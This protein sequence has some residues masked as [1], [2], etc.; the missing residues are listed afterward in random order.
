MG[1]GG[2]GHFHAKRHDLLDATAH[3]GDGY[4]A[5]ANT[6][7]SISASNPLAD[8]QYVDDE[9]ASVQ[10]GMHWQ[11]NIIEFRAMVTNE[12]GSPSDGDSYISTETGTIPSTTQAVTANDICRWNS[13]TSQW[14][15]QTPEDGWA[16]I[17]DG[18]EPNKAWIFNGTTW[19]DF[20]SM[21]NHATLLNRNW[22]VAAHT[23][24]TDFDLN[25]NKAINLADCTNDN[26]AVPYHRIREPRQAIGYYVSD[27]RGGNSDEDGSIFNPFEDPND[28][29]ALGVSNG[30]GVIILHMDTR[31]ATTYT[32]NVPAGEKV[33]VYGNEPLLTQLCIVKI[34]VGDGA[35]VNHD[36]VFVE[37][38]EESGISSGTIYGEESYISKIRDNAG[39][40]AASNLDGVFSNAIGVA[41]G[42]TDIKNM[43]S[44]FGTYLDLKSG[45]EEYNFF[46]PVVMNSS[47]ITDMADPTNP[48]DA[49][50][51]AYVDAFTPPF[52]SQFPIIYVS[53]LRGSDTLHDGSIFEPFLTVNKAITVGVA[54]G[55][56]MIQ[57]DVDATNFP[58]Y[59]ATVPDNALVSIRAHEGI[60]SS[61]NFSQI[62]YGDNVYLVLDNVNVDVLKE[63]ATCTVADVTCEECYVDDWTDNAGTGAPSVTT[64][65][66]RDTE[67]SGSVF[68]DLSGFSDV[69]GTVRDGSG[70]AFQLSGMDMDGNKITNVDDPAA[71]TDADTQG[72]RNT[73]ISTHA[74]IAAAHHAKYTDGE[75]VTAMGVKGDS[76]PLNHDR[77]VQATESAL[78]IAEIATQAETDAGSDDTKFITPDKLA[79]YSGLQGQKTQG[80]GGD[81]LQSSDSAYV[82]HLSITFQGTTKMG[83]PS[84]IYVN[85][86]MAGGG[87]SYDLRI[88]DKTNGD[89]V[90]CETTGKT[91]TAEQ[92]ID[93]GTLSNLPTGQA[94]WHL[95]V[96]KTGG[97]SARTSGGVIEW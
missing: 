66:F 54:L 64:A 24:D 88:I 60:Y 22:S 35:V 32:I 16:V 81:E 17:E 58:T 9:I 90:I 80:F 82:K 73:A 77:P 45:V 72:A 34:Y 28:A 87:T 85:A 89:A 50:T 8:K 21:L 42:L 91:N 33:S 37:I 76:N 53:D 5:L 4:D 40:G 69:Q 46:Q 39:T 47:Q 10:A 48:Q 67:L 55:F 49:A 18:V 15:I 71:D 31:S 92:I 96:K 86:F 70:K 59:T 95:Q 43:N 20:S 75:A 65:R 78:G 52:S 1:A 38:Y 62:E 74:A 29:I 51:K 68:S 36:N 27:D 11:D 97:G 30:D 6:P 84:K 79:N 12:P 26:D 93:L 2:D 25:S 44:F 61:A 83:T 14:D 23:I 13:G 3:S 57:I 19:G 7:N 56:G 41:A 63:S 94:L